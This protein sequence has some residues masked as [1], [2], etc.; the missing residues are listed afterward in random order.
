MKIRFWIGVIFLKVNITNMTD[1]NKIEK[2][3]VITNNP[4]PFH[5]N[6]PLNSS[7]HV[8]SRIL[9]WFSHGICYSPPFLVRH[10]LPPIDSWWRVKPSHLD[11]TH[12]HP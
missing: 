8:Q 7:I 6:I 5:K 1:D 10:C 12:I 9:L 11:T 4:N 3:L 2:N